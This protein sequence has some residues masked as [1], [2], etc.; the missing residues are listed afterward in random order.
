M[1]LQ[2]KLGPGVNQGITSTIWSGKYR[3]KNNME[4]LSI[5]GS[6]FQC[7][8]VFRQQHCSQ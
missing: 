5:V 7:S 2:L 6:G 3:I 1:D 4:R 8:G